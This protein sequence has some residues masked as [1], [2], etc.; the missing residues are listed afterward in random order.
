MNNNE[1][2]AVHLARLLIDACNHPDDQALQQRLRTELDHSD[3]T[4][5]RLSTAAQKLLDGKGYSI[6]TDNP[7][8]VRVF[9]ALAEHMGATFNE[10]VAGWP[11][12]DNYAFRLDP[13]R[14]H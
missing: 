11:A 7:E 3:Q 1:E 4:T 6:S 9:R 2:K 13:P 14:S 8:T 5:L 12:P 10:T